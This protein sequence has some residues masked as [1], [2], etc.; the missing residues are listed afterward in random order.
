MSGLA[1]IKRLPKKLY[2]DIEFRI[3]NLQHFNYI[4][5]N[6]TFNL[7]ATINDENDE[8]MD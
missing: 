7:D 8:S 4:R 3:S 2:M 1:F 6:S 5:V